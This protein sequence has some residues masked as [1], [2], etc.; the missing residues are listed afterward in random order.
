MAEK[1]TN[2]LQGVAASPGIAIGKAFLLEDDE[3]CL[4]QRE[5]S[6]EETKKEVNRFREALSK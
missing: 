6:R 2:I 1:A 5:I 4:I 3:F